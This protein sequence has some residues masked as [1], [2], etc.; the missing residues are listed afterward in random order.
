MSISNANDLTGGRA[1]TGKRAWLFGGA[2]SLLVAVAVIFALTGGGCTREEN[3]LDNAVDKEQIDAANKIVDSMVATY[4]EATTYRDK[5]IIEWDLHPPRGMVLHERYACALEFARPNRMRLLFEPVGGGPV[6]II[7]DEYYVHAAPKYFFNQLVK[8]KTPEKIEVPAFYETQELVGM[9]QPTVASMV[10]SGNT[11]RFASIPLD[12]L[13]GTEPLKL[14]RSQDK[15]PRLVEARTIGSQVCDGVSYRVGQR[16]ITLWV[17]QKD[18]LLRRVQI[19]PI[20]RVRGAMLER[21]SVTYHDAELNVTENPS[22]FFWKRTGHEYLVRQL[23]PPIVG[24]PATTSLEGQQVPNFPFVFED[25]TPGDMASLRGKITVIDLWATWC[26][27]CVRMMPLIDEVRKA[28]ADNDQV[29]FLA[30]S[31]DEPSEMRSE[32]VFARLRQLGVGIAG[33]HIQQVSSQA[34]YDQLRFD[35]IP[36]TLVIGPSGAIHFLRIGDPKINETLRKVLDSLLT[37]PKRLDEQLVEDTSQSIPLPVLGLAEPSKPRHWTLEKLWMNQRLAAPG[38]M[39][40]VPDA[41]GEGERIYAID[42]TRSVV[43]LGA[44]D[45]KVKARH[46]NLVPEGAG[47]TVLRSGITNDGAQLFAA[48]G[49]QSQVF[50][51]DDAWQ[52]KFA[53]PEEAGVGKVYDVAMGHI[54]PT[55][56]DAAGQEAG[57]LG[58]FVGY[59][60]AAGVHALTHDGKRLWRNRSVANVGDIAVM[61]AVKDQPGYLLCVNQDGSLRPI[62]DRGEGATPWRLGE[63]AAPFVAIAPQGKDASARPS[64]CAITVDIYGSRVALGLDEGGKMR[65]HYP[66]PTGEHGSYLDPMVFG[67]LDGANAP[68]Y[69]FIA[70]KDGS[71]HWIREDGKKDDSFATGRHISGIATATIDGRPVLLV[72]ADKIVTAYALS[73]KPTE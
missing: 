26:T 11:Q 25:G 59:Y 32:D 6:E 36:A 19:A 65:W 55:E 24:M 49:P 22:R 21:V 31:L 73:P 17:G 14:L 71:V 5:G 27:P 61:P 58:I 48:A 10:I 43:E 47:V 3:P 63:R 18:H 8:F 70:A 15:T 56:D 52:Q 30:I 23:V 40:V 54:A 41:S 38:N 35:G 57:D 44:S 39:L 16:E 9:L 2:N 33:A 7:S 28:Y 20:E 62:D 45:G 42:G 1:L 34:I 46:D 51:F 66:L 72:S 67:K 69:W 68:G 29:Q 53:Y 50:V 37:Y 12:L 4:R 60:D 64:I 13:A